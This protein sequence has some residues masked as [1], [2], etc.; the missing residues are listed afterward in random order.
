MRLRVAIVVNR[1]DYGGTE[2]T[3][4]RLVT[5]LSPHRAQILLVSVRGPGRISTRLQTEGHQVS[6]LGLKKGLRARPDQLLRSINAL[7][8][9]L[10]QQQIQLVQGFLFEGN[11]IARLAARRVRIP[12][13]SSLRGDHFALPGERW[14]EQSSGQLVQAYVAAS[15]ATA[16]AAHIHL[17]IPQA[18]IEVIY[19][20]VRLPQEIP[21]PQRLQTLGYL[22]RLHPEKGVDVLLRALALCANPALR[23]QLAGDGD[24]AAELRRLTHSLGLDAQVGFLGQ[25]KDPQKFLRSV[26]ALVVPSRY[27][28]LSNAAI[29][30]MAHS[31]PVIATDVGGN[32]EL[33][34]NGETGF[35]VA[36]NQAQT[37]A[38]AIEN[39]A[40]PK[41]L[42]AFAKA[43]RRRVQR[44]F[45]LPA[46]HQ[47][48]LRLWQQT[49]RFFPTS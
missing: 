43:G 8:D 7:A 14:I 38:Q 4:E 21:P 47:A 44:H 39:L 18:R 11:L 15:Q 10:R 25:V 23:L 22:G 45:S 46:M 49:V 17:G 31:R 28:G 37:M 30:A 26:D 36:P 33:V 1:L 6:V 29:E 40:P 24:Q 13:L 9:L 3:I 34:L 42:S 19:N 5:G 27:E 32:R 41:R 35:I 12:C 2:A 20:G 16:H 48:Y